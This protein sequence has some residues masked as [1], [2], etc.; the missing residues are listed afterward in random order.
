MD[1]R[2][3]IGLGFVLIGPAKPVKQITAANVQAV[4][5]LIGAVPPNFGKLKG[6]ETLT[7][8][9]AANCGISAAGPRL[10]Y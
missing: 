2:R 1:A 4:R 7:A 10:R 6:N 9:A 3:A 8:K 5:D